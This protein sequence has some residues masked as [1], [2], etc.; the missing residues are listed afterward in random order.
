MRSQS[1][2]L[3]RLAHLWLLAGSPSA[4]QVVEKVVDDW[5]LR[6]LP[7]SMRR[8]VSMRNPLDIA[9]LV[10]AVELTHRLLATPERERAWHPGGWSGVRW[11]APHAQSAGQG[12]PTLSTNLCPLNTP[13]HGA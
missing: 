12:S 8:P 5:L 4:D 13:D 10:E 11:R 2:Q 6:A 1:A 7:R 9:E 3:A